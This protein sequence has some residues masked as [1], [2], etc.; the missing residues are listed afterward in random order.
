[1]DNKIIAGDRFPDIGVTTV[2]GEQGPLGSPGGGA[3]WR[4][5]VVYRGRHCPLCTRYLG[6]LEAQKESLAEL[7]IDVIAV[8]GD[9]LEQ[10]QSHLQKMSLSFPVAYGLSI[11]QMQQLGLY[12]SHPRSEQ[13]TDHPFPEPGLF[14]VNSDGNVQLVDIS[15]GPFARPELETLV[16]GLRFVRE[17]DYPIRGTYG[18]YGA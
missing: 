10:A 2:T 1:M 15:N 5:V 17:N 9:S 6:L 14:V 8:S 4:M 12:I 18:T 13:E 16:N 7:G 11:E 3:E